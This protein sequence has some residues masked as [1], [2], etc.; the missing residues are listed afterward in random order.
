MI[1]QVLRCASGELPELDLCPDLVQTI[2]REL[3]ALDDRIDTL[4]HN[5]DALAGYLPGA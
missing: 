2:Q 4:R 3:Q 1:K 5:R